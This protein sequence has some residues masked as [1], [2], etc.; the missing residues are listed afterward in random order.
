MAGRQGPGI[1]I[2]SEL[3]RVVGEL[4][5]AISQPPVLGALILVAALLV[6]RLIVSPGR[7]V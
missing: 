5:D 3:V 4:I 1:S 7:Q 6:L 2:G